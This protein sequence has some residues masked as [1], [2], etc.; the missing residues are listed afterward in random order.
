[1]LKIIESRKSRSPPKRFEESF[2]YFLMC[3]INNLFFLLI[4][5]IQM[6]IRKIVVAISITLLFA[7]A[8]FI[9]TSTNQSIRAVDNKTVAGLIPFPVPPPTAPKV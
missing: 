7:I 1:M 4:K 3:L 5:E 2:F 6:S 8:L 9:Y